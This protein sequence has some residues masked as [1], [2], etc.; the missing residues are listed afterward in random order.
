MRRDRQIAPT[1]H[2]AVVRPSWLPPVAPCKCR[3]RGKQN[4]RKFSAPQQSKTPRICPEN[5]R[6]FPTSLSF[7]TSPFHSQLALTLFMVKSPRPRHS[8]KCTFLVL[9]QGKFVRNI[10]EN[11]RE[12]LM[13][14]ELPATW[15]PHPRRRGAP[16][17]SF[18]PLTPPTFPIC[19]FPKVQISASPTE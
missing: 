5:T 16:A 12:L 6:G 18:V 13:R 2:P 14:L 15:L 3:Q 17:P 19:R 8:R 4:R 11:R 1:A 7:R 10:P 9:Q